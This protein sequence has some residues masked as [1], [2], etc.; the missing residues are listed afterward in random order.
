M[1]CLN[2][3]VWRNLIFCVV[4]GLPIGCTLTSNKQTSS[5]Q[6]SSASTRLTP[7]P[8]RTK[9][10]AQQS[11]L[12]KTGRLEICQIN[13]FKVYLD[14]VAKVQGSVVIIDLGYLPTDMMTGISDEALRLALLEYPSCN[15]F[16]VKWSATAF[17]STDFYEQT[18]NRP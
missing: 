13:N 2:S 8:T 11:R 16:K 15:T 17:H 5:T 1:V 4:A 6:V 12:R 7:T 9:L 10:P 3:S 14:E 18:Y